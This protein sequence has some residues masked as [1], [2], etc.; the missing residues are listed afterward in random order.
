MD[1]FIVA[2]VSLARPESHKFRLLFLYM[3]VTFED[4]GWNRGLTGLSAY[5]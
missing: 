1:D 2:P 5:P 3:K 4:I